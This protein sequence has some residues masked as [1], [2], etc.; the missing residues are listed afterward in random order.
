[1]VR[2]GDVWTVAMPVLGAMDWA[3]ATPVWAVYILV[4]VLMTLAIF[5]LIYYFLE[6]ANDRNGQ[7]H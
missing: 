5:Y 4:S 7:T 6:R 2:D 3:D 1:M